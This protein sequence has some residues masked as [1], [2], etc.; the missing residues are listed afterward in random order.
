MR[1]I[2]LNL[3]PSSRF[4]K[5]E[6][7]WCVI[8]ETLSSHSRWLVLVVFHCHFIQLFLSALKACPLGK[9]LLYSANKT[10]AV[11]ASPLAFLAA[12]ELIVPSCFSPSCSSKEKLA[13][14]CSLVFSAAQTQRKQ[15]QLPVDMIDE[16]SQ[17]QR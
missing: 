9:A 3:S 16:R 12:S 10:A 15:F 7:T 5:K 4:F 13:S 17:Q 6:I 2:C 1:Y 11:V 8:G 14:G